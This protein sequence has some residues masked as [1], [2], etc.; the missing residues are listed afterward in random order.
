MGSNILPPEYY[1][2][3]SPSKSSIWIDGVLVGP[4]YTITGP[5]PVEVRLKNLIKEL[6][7]ELAKG[8]N[9]YMLSSLLQQ[10]EEVLAPDEWK[11]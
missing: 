4:N 11:D 5:S 9:I 6:E 10:L 1:T 8:Q 2:S 3:S 7:T